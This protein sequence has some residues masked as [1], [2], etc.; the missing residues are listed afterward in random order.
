MGL[1]LGSLL[2]R[3]TLGSRPI[4]RDLESAIRKDLVAYPATLTLDLT[5]IAGTA[6]AFI[7]E[8][9]EI[10]ENSV[11]SAK[12]L[13]VIQFVNPPMP[14]SHRFKVFE[15]SRGVTFTQAPDGTWIAHWRTGVRC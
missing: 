10:V 3:R 1:K 13:P 9:L 11:P 14:I 12:D 4:A 7:D 2:E 5:G 8:V 15:R 6:P